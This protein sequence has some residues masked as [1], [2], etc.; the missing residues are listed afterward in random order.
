M[1]KFI[2][3]KLQKNKYIL[4]SFKVTTVI[5]QQ[6]LKSSKPSCDFFRNSSDF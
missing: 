5:L 6:S 3:K 2:V 1:W 4:M